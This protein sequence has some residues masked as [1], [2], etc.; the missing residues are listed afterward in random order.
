MSGS[1][2]VIQLPP[3]PIATNEEAPANGEGF[4]Q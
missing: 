1:I 2:A 4:L 3:I